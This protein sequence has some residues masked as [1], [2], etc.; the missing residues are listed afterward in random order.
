MTLYNEPELKKP[1]KVRFATMGLKLGSTLGTT[2]GLLVMC[3]TAQGVKEHMYLPQK[4][5]ALLGGIFFVVLPAF[6]TS[7]TSCAA[8]TSCGLCIQPDH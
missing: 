8:T 6:G 3:I 5:Q 7:A 1:K 4:V 2:V